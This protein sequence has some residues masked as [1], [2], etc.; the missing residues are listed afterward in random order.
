[1][2]TKSHEY[3]YTGWDSSN[4]F[5]PPRPTHYCKCGAE[6][7][8]GHC[9]VEEQNNDHGTERSTKTMNDLELRFVE[10]FRAMANE[11]DR[12]NKANGWGVN[13][14]CVHCSGRGFQYHQIPGAGVRV[15]CDPCKGSGYKD[16]KLP[17][18]IVEKMALCHTEISEAVEAIRHGNPE[19]DHLPG[20]S[21]LAEELADEIIRVMTA[22][23]EEGI[24]LAPIVV[25]KVKFNATRGFRHGGKR[26]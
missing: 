15:Y 16:G 4:N 1:M 12:V 3:L 6:M 19:S 9:T 11:A 7:I 22:A 21:G 18:T 8:N 23:V 26:I 17:T 24:D 20:V 13:E 2:N 14:K 10:S 25:E 5:G